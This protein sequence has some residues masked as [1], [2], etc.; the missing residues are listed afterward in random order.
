MLCYIVNQ[1]WWPGWSG[2]NKSPNIQQHPEEIVGIKLGRKFSKT[3]FSPGATGASRDQTALTDYY[4]WTLEKLKAS[5]PFICE[6]PQKDI[7]CMCDGK[8]Y[9]GVANRTVSGAGVRCLPWKNNPYLSNVLGPEEIEKLNLDTKDSDFNHCRN[10]DGD[11]L[12][13]CIVEGGEFDICD[14]PE[15][16]PARCGSGT[17]WH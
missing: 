5:I 6:G 14:V 15:C 2:G 7:G 1:Y 10:P 8:L 16:D 12:P 17:K 4:F 9:T 11:D 13:W 3:R